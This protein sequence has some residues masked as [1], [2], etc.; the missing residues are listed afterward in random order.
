MRAWIVLV[1]SLLAG[2]LLAWFAT[3]TPAPLPVDAPPPAFSAER[4]FDDVSAIARRPHPTGS[5]E[6]ARVRDYLLAR[7]AQL[8]LELRIGGVQASELGR[9]AEALK[10]KSVENVLAV[11]PGRDRDAPAVL[12]M[13]HYDSV[14]G[15]P[16]AADDAS[17]VAASLEIAR[18][19]KAAGTPARDVIFLFTDGEEIG[20][21]ARAPSSSASPSPAASASSSTWRRAAAAAGP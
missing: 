11:L 6:N 4:A 14:P 10:G 18:A 19:L 7:V 2:L 9:G 1:A 3:R 13:S 21:W 8:G 16:G 5:P 12:I 20:L 17:G 15:S